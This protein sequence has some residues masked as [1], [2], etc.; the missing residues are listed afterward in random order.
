MNRNTASS[1]MLSCRPP[2][3]DIPAFSDVVGRT[4]AESRNTPLKLRT[5]YPVCVGCAGGDGGSEFSVIV[6][7]SAALT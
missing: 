4:N 7:E 5:Y 2:W 1:V 3:R 6:T